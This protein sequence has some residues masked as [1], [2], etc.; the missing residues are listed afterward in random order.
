V[1]ADSSGALYSRQTYYAFGGVR[2][3]QGSASP[4]D[5]G[6]T[7]EKLD[8]SDGLMYYGVRYYDPLLGRFTQPDTIIPGAGNPQNFNRYSYVI[9]NPLRYTDPTGHFLDPGCG[10]D[11]DPTTPSPD[12]YTPPPVLNNGCD[13]SVNPGCGLAPEINVSLVFYRLYKFFQ[14]W[15]M[16]D[17]L[18]NWDAQEGRGRVPGVGDQ[19]VQLRPIGQAQAWFGLTEAVLWEGY[20]QETRRRRNWQGTLIEAWQTVERDL[21]VG[22]IF[23]LPHEPAFER[24]YTGFLS[25]MGYR[26]DLANPEWWSKKITQEE[27]VQVDRSRTQIL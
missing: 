6:F 22:K 10:C 1:V 18:V 12:P 7:G 8:A 13:P 11:G 27:L 2:T 3:T 16:A 5:Y 25:R 26:L 24:G 21:K 4:T 19:K 20:F 17:V 15:P 23:T 14:P 9:N